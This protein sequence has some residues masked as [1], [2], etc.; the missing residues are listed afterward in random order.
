MHEALQCNTGFPAMQAYIRQ[1][2]AAQGAAACS[3]Q[4][5]NPTISRQCHFHWD[6]LCNAC[7]A[8]GRQTWPTASARS[9]LRRQQKQFAT[10]VCADFFRIETKAYCRQCNEK[11]KYYS[12]LPRADFCTMRPAGARGGRQGPPEA[13]NGG[14]ARGQQAAA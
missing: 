3:S 6:S 14:G 8:K 2:S 7:K 11:P 4:W 13:A 9:R 1:T 5:H 10:T 12:G